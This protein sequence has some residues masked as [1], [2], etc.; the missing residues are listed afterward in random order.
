ME[1]IK[2]VRKQTGHA[3]NPNLGFNQVEK[4]MG[5]DTQSILIVDD[6]S[7]NI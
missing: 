5:Q 4:K 7:F 6:Q 1:P 3:L 2:A